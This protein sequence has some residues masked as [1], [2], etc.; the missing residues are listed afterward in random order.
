MP[1]TDRVGYVNGVGQFVGRM[2]CRPTF[3]HPVEVDF[4]MGG[5][6]SFRRDVAAR[7]EFDMELNRNVAQ[8]YE[9]DIGLQVR[10]Q[11]WK[12]IFDPL[13][14]IR[15][16]SA[17]RA[18]RRPADVDAE[19]IQWYAFN[20]LRVGLRRLSAAAQVAFAASTNSLV[21][22]RPAPGFLPLVLAPIARRVR[23]RDPSRARG[24]ERPPARGA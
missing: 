15:H 14:A 24:A 10:R 19:S 20:Q 2:Y 8:G 16:Y 18:D 6:M 5:N 11:G 7:L 3:S 23:L 1:D 12:I 9:I 21:G 17:P 4:L 22:E 13:L